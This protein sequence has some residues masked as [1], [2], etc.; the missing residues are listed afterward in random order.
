M[1][2]SCFD[3]PAISDE[4][5]A[6]TSMYTAERER[7]D[8]RQAVSS[9]ESWLANLETKVVLEMLTDANLPRAAQ[10]LNKTNQMNMVT[11]RLPQDELRTWAAVENHALWTV[12][13]SYRFGD[14]GLSGIISLEL[15]ADSANIV[16]FLMSCRV[17][18]R[19]IEET[20]LHVAVEHVR[21]H[22]RI[23][24]INAELIPTERNRPCREFW[25]RSGFTEVAEDRYQWATG[26]PYP[27]PS[28]IDLAGGAPS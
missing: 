5:R 17:M 8:A 10:L 20:M 19:Q 22:S 9:M 2:L 15:C 6:R 3:T 13:V 28:H 11:R 18:G 21:A 14:S 12:R 25:Q 24:Q 1:A 16:D 23:K 26:Q 27:K 4:D 7:R